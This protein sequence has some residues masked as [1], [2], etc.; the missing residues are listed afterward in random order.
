MLAVLTHVNA[1]K[2]SEEAEPRVAVLQSARVHYRGEIVGA[3]IAETP[4]MAEEAARLVRLDYDAEPHDTVLRSDHPGLYK[5]SKVNPDFPTDTSK[6]DFDAAFSR[7]ERDRRHLR[8]AGLPQQ[9]DGAA[10]DDRPLGR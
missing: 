8:D 5:P 6:G 7:A 3:V 9:S 4:E 2:L 10:C 1:L